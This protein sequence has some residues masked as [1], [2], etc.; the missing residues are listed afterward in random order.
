MNKLNT[1]PGVKIINWILNIIIV[2][3]TF[4][5]LITAGVMI[6]AIVEEASPTHSENSFYYALE[7]G[8][9]AEL[10]GNCYR[11]TLAGHEGSA[12]M[13]EYY[14][15]AMYYEAASLYNAYTEVGNEAQ[16]TVFLEKMKLAEEEMGGWSIAKDA[17]HKQLGIE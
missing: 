11:N 6:E 8:R 12:T 13:Q 3:A 17:I 16:A 14:G 5:F 1:K 15:V 9:Y 2:I 4:F 10:V 7:D